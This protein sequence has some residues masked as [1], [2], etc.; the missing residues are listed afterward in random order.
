MKDKKSR[1]S[2]FGRK[3]EIYHSK[4]LQTNTHT[5]EEYTLS[6]YYTGVLGTFKA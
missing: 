6:L 1:K 3:G 4:H 2:N 5:T